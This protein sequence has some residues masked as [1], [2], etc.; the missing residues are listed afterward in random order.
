MLLLHQ[1]FVDIGK[2]RTFRDNELYSRLYDRN[3]ISFDIKVWSEADLDKLIEEYPEFIE[4][5][6]SFP[7]KFYKIDFMRPLIL[8][9]EGG[10]YMDMD[11]QI[12]GNIVIAPNTYTGEAY[13]DVMYFRNRHIYLQLARYMKDRYYNCNMPESWITRRFMYSVGQKA[14]NRFCKKKGIDREI[15]FLYKGYDTQMWIKHFRP[16]SKIKPFIRD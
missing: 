10:F 12:L 4:M 7:S 13:N 16:N 5:Y 2:G 8:H 11:N 6:N 1:I 9:K 14:Y 3:S 15:D